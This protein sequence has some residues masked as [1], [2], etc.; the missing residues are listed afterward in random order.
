MTG[1]GTV[2]LLAALPALGNFAGR[3]LLAEAVTVS[4]RVLSLALHAALGIVVAVVSLELLPEALDT[5][6][7][8]VPIVAFKLGGAFL[9]LTDRFI[10]AFRGPDPARRDGWL[11]AASR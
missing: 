2:L 9:L 7:Q 10:H 11:R 1:F 6:T 3:P 4:Q 5:D 8:W